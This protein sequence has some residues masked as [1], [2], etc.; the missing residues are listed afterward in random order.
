MHQAFGLTWPHPFFPFQKIGVERLLSEPQVLLA[1]EMGL[2]KTIQ[3]IAALRLLKRRGGIDIA[4]I[5]APTGL[6]LQWRRQLRDW[7]PEF[8]LSTAIGTQSERASAWRAGADVYLASYEGLRTDVWSRGSD[9][10]GSRAW[11][12]VVLDEAQRIK[13]ANAETSLAAKRLSR[14]RSWALTGTPLENRLDDLI[15][16]L[17]FVAPG[18]F[19]PSTKAVG[20]RRLLTEVQIRRRRSDVLYDLPPKFTSTVYL[21]LGR[22]Q[23]AAYRRAETEGI[24]R[25]EALGREI[26]SRMCWS[27][28]C[29][30]NRSVISAPRAANPPSSSTCETG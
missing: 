28:S 23:R 18:R 1:D 4:L 10:P 24:V 15:S 25:L 30:S 26:K 16:I 13:T 27:S 14:S 22:R 8:R 17:D 9:M 3:A 7:A 21:A 6:V 20:L 2:G 11:D 12:V 29:N 5:V 19:D